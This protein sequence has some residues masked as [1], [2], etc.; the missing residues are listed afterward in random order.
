ML[1]NLE[2]RTTHQTESCDEVLAD[3]L[4]TET[5]A[6]SQDRMVPSPGHR[7]GG[8]LIGY[9]YQVVLEND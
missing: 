2:T 4:L 1:S 3:S 5:G 9:P 6:G 8:R 7:L